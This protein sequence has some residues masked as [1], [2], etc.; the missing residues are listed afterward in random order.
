MVDPIFNFLGVGVMV[1]ALTVGARVVPGIAY[2]GVVS[3]LGAAILYI[4]LDLGFYAVMPSP[5]A[6]IGPLA[7]IG[8]ILVATG[9]LWVVGHVV[10][11]F[12]VAGLASALG[13]ALP[14]EVVK[15][16][17]AIFPAFAAMCAVLP[18]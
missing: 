18:R 12:A 6:A 14:L 11:G 15:F 9:L 1:V 10:P 16:V 17:I 8:N 5:A 4:V 13:G 2:E 7:I 3:L